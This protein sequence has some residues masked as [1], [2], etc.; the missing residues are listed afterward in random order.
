[1]DQDSLDLSLEE[2]QTDDEYGKGLD[3]A[4]RWKGGARGRV[5]VKV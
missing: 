5:R 1:M 2:V 3:E 4:W